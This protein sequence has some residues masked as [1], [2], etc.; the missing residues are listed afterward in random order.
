MVIVPE[1]EAPAA[2]LV[3]AIV[4]KESVEPVFDEMKNVTEIAAT[5]E[6][7]PDRSVA[8]ACNSCSVAANADVS[9]TNR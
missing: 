2:G 7:L 8:T 6:A 1:T 4:V 3:N 9:I 5:D